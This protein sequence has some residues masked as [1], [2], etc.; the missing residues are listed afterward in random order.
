MSNPLINAH[1][2]ATGEKIQVYKHRDGT[3][4]DYADCNTCYRLRELRL[5]DM[6][7]EEIH[8]A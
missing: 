5:F 4:I 8:N 7:G 1:V 3:W 6:N 2:I